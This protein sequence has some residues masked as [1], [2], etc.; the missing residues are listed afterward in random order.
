ML[1]Y[2]VWEVGEVLDSG[3]SSPVFLLVKFLIL[4]YTRL[5]FVSLNPELR[6]VDNL[7]LSRNHSVYQQKAL[8]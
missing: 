3:L 5:G 8:A 1:F 7:R 2:K 6:R 4:S